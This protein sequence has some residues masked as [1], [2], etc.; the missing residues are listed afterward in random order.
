MKTAIRIPQTLQ[1]APARKQVLTLLMASFCALATSAVC[2]PVQAQTFPN[3]PVRIIL[4]VGAGNPGDV[5][6]RQIAARF[7]EVFGQ[8]LIVENRPGGNGFI[9][10]EAAA[11]APADGYTLFLGNSGTHVYNPWLFKKMP[12]RDVE[13]FA[14][15]TLIAGGPLILAVNPQLPVRTLGELITLANSKPGVLNY[16]SAG[17]FTDVLMHQV[18]TSTGINVVGVPYKTPGGDLTDTI[19]GQIQITL[20]FWPILEPLVKSGKLRAIAIAA[21]NR[22]PASPDLPTFAEAGVPGIDLFAWT[23]LFVPAGTPPDIIDRLQKGVSQILQTPAL[24]EEI[25]KSGATPGGTSTAEFTALWLADRAKT[26][27]FLA[28][29]GILPE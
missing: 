16:G 21:P 9:A 28:A 3:K 22:H 5:R 18:K 12:Y 1:V 27:K 19:A 24:R 14:P 20:N 17:S 26:G 7:P 13:D 4:P 15:V 29:A 10:A 11:R 8:T 25:I 23:G 2:T 6:A